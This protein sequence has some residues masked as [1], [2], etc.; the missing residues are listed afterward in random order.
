ML[1][2]A[3]A[4]LLVLA[5]AAVPVAASDEE[6]PSASIA[7]AEIRDGVLAVAGTAQFVGTPEQVVAR[8]GEGVDPDFPYEA[9]GLEIAE[10]RVSQPDPDTGDIL[11]TLQMTDLPSNGGVPEVARYF[12]DFGVTRPSGGTQL[13]TYDGQYT[14]LAR[15]VYGASP[16]PSSPRFIL[17]ANCT[18][19][20]ANTTVCEPLL[21][22]DAV[23]DGATDRI[24]V[25]VPLAFV[26]EQIEGDPVGQQVV[27]A[28]LYQGIAAAPS[29]IISP[30]AAS[31]IAGAYAGRY[32]I[33][34][35]EVT[36]E[37]LD[38]TG[39]VAR[40]AVATVGEGDAFSGALDVSDLPAGAYTLRSTAC[41][42]PGCATD[43]TTVQLP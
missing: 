24:D 27:P 1:R 9:L 18:T 14:G 6:G 43:A 41:F 7:S 38:A 32:R 4:P 2:R 12:W 5:L 40:S 31:F 21:Q 28:T 42:G 35:K 16:D 30:G 33:A 34:G 3:L 13:F 11:L 25:T 23:M 29:A 37:L 8:G 22:L 26:A 39:A 20:T 36:L 19:D 10:A 17:E 15:S